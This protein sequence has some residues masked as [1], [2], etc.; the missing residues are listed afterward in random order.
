MKKLIS[1]GLI[2]SI[3]IF[4][5][6][7]ITHLK[8]NSISPDNLKKINHYGKNHN[9]EVLQFDGVKISASKIEIGNDTLYAVTQQSGQ[10]IKI[11]L[12]HVD[13]IKI[14]D[15]KLGLGYGLFIGAGIGALIGFGIGE[16]NDMGGVAVISSMILGGLLG[17]I[18]GYIVG[19]S[20]GYQFDDEAK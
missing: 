7:N 12:A 3:L 14:K 15:A 16:G 9:S 11:P 13:W 20:H 4:S 17:G 19:G 5:C 10:S 1:I 6:T 8:R 2:L 18:V